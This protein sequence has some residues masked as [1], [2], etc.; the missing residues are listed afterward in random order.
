M[1]HNS[2]PYKL[3]NI[4]HTK[5]LLFINLKLKDKIKKEDSYNYYTACTIIIIVT[6]HNFVP[7]FTSMVVQSTY[8]KCV[9]LYSLDL[10]ML[11]YRKINTKW[12]MPSLC[13]TLRFTLKS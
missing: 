9:I 11:V 10:E 5:F 7:K 2:F 12:N 6:L 8:V 1:W 13:P 4:H 3:Y